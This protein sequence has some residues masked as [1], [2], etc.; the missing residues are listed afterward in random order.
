MSSSGRL[1][2]TGAS[3]RLAQ[4]VIQAL[5]DTHK[6]PPSNII[7]VSRSVDKLADLKAKGIDV[8]AG[9]LD[10][11]NSLKAAFA[12]GERVLLISTMDFEKIQ[13]HLENGIR[14]AQKAGLKH[15]V[16]TGVVTQPANLKPFHTKLLAV[17]ET[18]KKT[19]GITYTVV[20]FNL[21]IESYLEWLQGAIATG[22]YYTT[23]VSGKAAYGTRADFAKA[24]AAAL[25]RNSMTNAKFDITGPEAIDRRQVAAILTKELSLAKPIE[26][27]EISDDQLLVL[28]TDAKVP[29]IFARF[30]VAM[31]RT[32]TD[33]NYSLV[34]K[35]FYE[36]TG[37]QPE[38][39]EAFVARNKASY[40]P[41]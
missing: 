27:K 13:I 5:L 30:M 40:A 21:W 19:S 16:V 4:F 14:E 31:D 32:I 8:R 20:G 33:G 39:F 29:E 37:T 7:A 6:V 36:L 34:G 1:I 41:K 26:V 24:C 2:V 12:G 11:P 35:G 15:V 17:E 22:I 10:D 28:L 23:R 18:L 38:S 9:D 3:G 25:A